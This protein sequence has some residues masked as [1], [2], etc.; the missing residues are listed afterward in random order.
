MPATPKAVLFDCDGV[1]VDSEPLT[2][3]VLIDNLASHGFRVDA[4]ELSDLL[5]G[6]TMKSL[7]ETARSLGADL[8]EDWLDEIYAQ[9]FDRLR[10]G[11]PVI[12]GVVDLLDAL[13]ARGIPYAIGSNGPMDKMR[14]TL[15][16]N[17]LWDR[18]APHIYSAHEHAAPK[19]APDLY[20]FAARALGHAPE[21]CVVI[22]DS[23]PGCRGGI[24]AGCR[25]IGYAETTDA[26]PLRALGIETVG[27]MAEI[28][29]LLALGHET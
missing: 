13:D 3:A 26:E 25:T 18:F 1:L 16:Q 12:A 6:G 23:P 22:D 9:M 27:S 19:P 24:A 10:A 15:G 17:A 11:T 21:D 20:R 29:D 28:L 8:P 7:G 4:A 5:L 14:I 2:E